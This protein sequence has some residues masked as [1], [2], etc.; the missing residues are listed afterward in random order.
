MIQDDLRELLEE[1]KIDQMQ[2]NVYKLFELTEAGKEFLY[3][4]KESIL[5]MNTPEPTAP[6]FAWVDGRRSWIRDILIDL[7]V[8][9]RN[10]EMLKNE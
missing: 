4:M 8:V 1:E 10:L 5:R 7:D 9:N 2:Y 6:L 3:D